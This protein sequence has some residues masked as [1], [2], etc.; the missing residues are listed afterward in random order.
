MAYR[1]MEYNK[2]GLF[3]SVI[4]NTNTREKF[5][6]HKSNLQNIFTAK[7]QQLPSSLYQSSIKIKVEKLQ[8]VRALA[9]KYVPPQ[10]LWFYEQLESLN[11]N[12]NE[13]DE[14]I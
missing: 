9:A 4:A 3:C 11:T 8:D 6:I 5:I 14:E 13:P 10:Y 1:T 7:H 12:N 2:N